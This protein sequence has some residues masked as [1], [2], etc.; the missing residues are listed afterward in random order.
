MAA[1]VSPSIM[2][3]LVFCNTEFP[4]RATAYI[5]AKGFRVTY[6]RVHLLCFAL[7]LLPFGLRALRDR[8]ARP[9]GNM[10]KKPGCFFLGKF[11]V[12]GV[13]LDLLLIATQM[14]CFPFTCI[15][16]TVGL[17][18]LI[19]WCGISAYVIAVLEEWFFRACL[20]GSLLRSCGERGAMVVSAFIFA[21]SHF[22]V[23]RSLDIPVAEVVW[24][25][26]FLAMYRHL[27]GIFENFE[28]VPFAILVVLGVVLSQL[29]LFYRSLLPAVGFHA[30]IVWAL[31][32]YKKCVNVEMMPHPF[33]GTWRL[34]DAPAT[35]CVL[36]GMSWVL[37]RLACKKRDSVLP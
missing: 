14:L 20:L 7:A 8:R 4:N 24:S 5:L 15:P 11:F 6:D 22:R 36:L 3:L 25:S 17:L 1:I 27:V 26:G 33:L 19:L 23:S 30:G 35:L 31:M 28:L 34:M 21:H 2:H 37:H 32:I 18:R 29:M 16:W 9:W 13:M 10:E 12:I